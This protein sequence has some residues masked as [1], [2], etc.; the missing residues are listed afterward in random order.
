M[1]R[2]PRSY[3]IGPVL[4]GGFG[5]AAPFSPLS[6]SFLVDWRKADGVLWQDSARTIPAT[7]TDDPV[8]AYDPAGVGPTAI[9]ATAGVRPKLVLSALN[10]L[11]AIRSIDASR[12]LGGALVVAQPL[13]IALVG[14]TTN[15][16][17]T[18][19]MFLWDGSGA[20]IARHSS[21][22]L[23][24]YAGSQLGTYAADAN[25]HVFVGLF[26]GAASRWRVD[27]ALAA[28]GD[29][30]ALGISSL[31]LFANPSVAFGLIGDEYE[32]AIYSALKNAR[33]VH[34]L[35]TYLYG[36]F[37]LG[38]PLLFTPK[39][40]IVDG[41]SLST[42]YG[43][44]SLSFPTQLGTLLGSSWEHIN[45]AVAG[46]TVVSMLADVVGQVDWEYDAVRTKDI[47]IC[48]GGINDVVGADTAA[49][50]YANISSYCSGRRSAGFKVIVCTIIPAAS[51]TGANETKR[52]AVN[53]SIR[54]GWT[55][56]ADAL[57]DLTTDPNIGDTG[58]TS[59]TT[60]YQA[61]G[62]HLTDVGRGIVASMNQTQVVAL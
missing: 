60:Y 34:Q 33:E 36:R 31:S 14:K 15:G 3:M 45:F 21:N 29:A 4:G 48:W 6:L 46:Q 2:R 28:Y 44:G 40:F 42:T 25:P 13:T 51:A 53:T 18:Y 50:V 30:G 27:G 26:N 20:W 37:A 8:G 52:Q 32:S 9:Q 39:M 56:F 22:W 12:Q 17:G 47:V 43:G 35:E 38:L 41:D 1:S 24:M 59:N 16:A 54:S 11:P 55:G 23:N 57:C 5:G 61:D 19:G 10:G 49:T 62:I 58:S 7:A